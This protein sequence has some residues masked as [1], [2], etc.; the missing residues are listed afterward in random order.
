MD[1]YD[2][3]DG[4]ISVAT[5]DA[6]RSVGTLELDGRAALDPHTRPVEEQLIQLTGTGAVRLYEDAE[7]PDAVADPTAPTREVRLA[8]GERVEIPA[9]AVHAHANPSD[10]SGVVLWRFDGDIRGVIEDIGREHEPVAS[11]DAD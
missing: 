9:G 10:E 4:R 1:L 11:S 7:R 2:L 3:P 5:C 6:E 8:P